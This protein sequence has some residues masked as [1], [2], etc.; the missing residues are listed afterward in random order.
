MQ[1][2]RGRY[3]ALMCL[4]FILSFFI[5]SPYKILS[6]LILGS[7]AVLALLL[8]FMLKKKREVVFILILLCCASCLIGLVRS[9][10]AID[11]SRKK[12]LEYEG[13]RTVEMTVIRYGKRT[14][15]LSEYTVNITK[16]GG[17]KT[18]IRAI[19]VMP[20]QLELH[21]GDNVLSRVELVSP[22]EKIWGYSAYERTN[23][24]K[25]LLTAVIYD[26]KNI[27]VLNCGKGLSLWDTVTQKGGSEIVFDRVRL[28]IGNAFDTAFGR[29]IS[30]LA[31]GFFMNDTSDIS[32]EISRDF[33]RCG[34]SHLMAVSGMHIT[35]LLGAIDRL[36]VNFFV[37]KKIRC[38]IVS[39]LSVGLLI[40]TGFSSSASRSVIMLWITYLH[41]ILADDEDSVTSLFFAIFIILM[42]SPYSYFELGLWMSFLA[43]L[44]IVTVY[45]YIDENISKKR[46][47][48]WYLRILKKLGL[49]MSAIVLMTI[50]A[51]LFVLPIS[52]SIFR[53]VSLVSI[54]SNII[55]SPISTLFLCEIPIV[56]LLCKIPALNGPLL[57]LMEVTI[58]LMVNIMRHFSKWDHAV[59]SL[60][61]VFADIIVPVLIVVLIICLIVYVKYKWLMI[62]P[63]TIAVLAFGICLAVTYVQ[64]PPKAIYVAEGNEEMIVI[65]ENGRTVLCD[66]SCESADM[67]YESYYLANDCGGN[68]IDTMILGHLSKN[69]SRIIDRIGRFTFID[70]IWLPEPI[71]QTELEIAKDVVETAESIGAAV[72]IYK[73]K[74]IFETEQDITV[75]IDREKEGTPALVSVFKGSTALN[76]ADPSATDND[77]SLQNT[78]NLG[79]FAI[80]SASSDDHE[81]D[82]IILNGKNLELL[83]FSSEDTYN[84]SIIDHKDVST[85]VNREKNKIW[86]ISFPLE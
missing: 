36:L 59:L 30:P 19:V 60:N 65:S 13:N 14:E 15:N 8:W 85:Y 68:K 42:I 33:R 2:F 6:M 78:L 58:D 81:E 55:L 50:V 75:Y 76:F 61:Y 22:N 39:I 21:S 31:K 86:N 67:Y 66:I 38:V 40:I 25:I 29:D 79:R 9:Y 34:V 73:D 64:Q 27:S 69:Q 70:N 17:D 4:F 51:N 62:I 5:P 44:G 84:S 83:V 32:T 18:N 45:S 20:F 48:K 54:F 53:E 35:I 46:P 71:S 43:T 56:F 11:L 72:Y 49:G 1:L 10:T 52:W 24:E 77:I 57:K 12:A 26:L 23:D 7:V 63:P 41:F 82:S 80:I 37:D 28:Y 47:K 16:I 3:V 74:E